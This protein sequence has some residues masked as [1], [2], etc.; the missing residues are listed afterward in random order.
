VIFNPD[1]ARGLR[2]AVDYSR[3]D[4]T[5]EVS[6]L[7]L[8]VRPFLAS[9]ESSRIQ[10]A[11]LTEEDRALGFTAGRVISADLRASNEGQTILEAVDLELD[12]Q[13]PE[14]IYG[15]FRLYGSATW[16]PRLQQRASLQ[17]PVLSRVGYSRG[18]LEW[19]GNVGLG[20]RLGSTTADLNLQL[21]DSYRVAPAG[22]SEAV[23]EQLTKYQGASEVPSQ[24]YLDFS[25]SRRFRVSSIAVQSINISFAVHN[26]LDASPPLIAN[27]LDIPYSPYGDSRLR[28]FQLSASAQF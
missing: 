22:A 24:A 16:L 25:V 18:P 4:R 10:R 14:T 1:A 27:P 6:F 13:L 7:P 11:P 2:I 3:I 15:S 5:R 28:R 20:W 26:L 21:Y 19:R 23:I 17:A 9:P 8:D 12:W